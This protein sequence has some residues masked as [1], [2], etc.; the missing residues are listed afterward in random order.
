MKD[1]TVWDFSECQIGHPCTNCTNDCT[2]R[3][4]KDKKMEQEKH[5][6]DNC[7]PP[8][9]CGYCTLR[10]EWDKVHPKPENQE[11]KKYNWD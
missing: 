1:E 9:M 4:R 3:I 11:L 6:C 10:E 5:P 2:F 7:P 8:H